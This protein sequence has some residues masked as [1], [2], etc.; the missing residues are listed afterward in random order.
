MEESLKISREIAEKIHKLAR[1][2]EGEG[3]KAMS[4]ADWSGGWAYRHATDLVWGIFHSIDQT[5]GRA[6]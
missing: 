4:K 5:K 1:R 3:D 2:L 6:E